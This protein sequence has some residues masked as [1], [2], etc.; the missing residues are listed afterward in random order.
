MSSDKIKAITGTVR[1]VSSAQVAG[2][3]S[4]YSF[5][6]FETDGGEMVKVNALVTDPEVDQVVRPGQH[7]TYHVRTYRGLRGKFNL[8][9]ATETDI[10]P[11]FMKL[12]FWALFHNFYM[13][14]VGGLVYSLIFGGFLIGPATYG[15]TGSKDLSFFLALIPLYLAVWDAIRFTG[16][17]G[18]ITSLKRDLLGGRSESGR[19]MVQVTNI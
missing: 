4:K 8:L 7:G 6:L 10:G 19:E 1:E 12:T 5:V 18:E 16:L 9:M 3:S 2:G 15:M 14:V 17:A 11:G 13:S